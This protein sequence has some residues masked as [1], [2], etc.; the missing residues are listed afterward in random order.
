MKC[1]VHIKA[2]GVAL[3]LRSDIIKAQKTPLPEYLTIKD[4]TKEAVKYQILLIRFS[5][6]SY[7]TLIFGGPK[8]QVKLEELIQ[9]MKNR[10]C[11]NIRS[12]KPS[13]KLRLGMAINPSMP[14]V[15]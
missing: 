4:I 7:V 9:L 11:F 3:A 15:H 12:K 5:I 1:N 14:R 2:R 13:K 8:Q 6:T 10:F